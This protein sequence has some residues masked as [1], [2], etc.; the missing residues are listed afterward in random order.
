MPKASNNKKS[1]SA[2]YVICLDRGSY[3]IDLQVGKVYRAA[4]SEKNDPKD[5]LR[6]VDDSGEDYLY[7][8]GWF[9]P[10]ELPPRARRAL[11]VVQ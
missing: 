5:M 3:R 2:S 11:A 1:R 8:A 4:V 10:V 9:A 6:V 7:P